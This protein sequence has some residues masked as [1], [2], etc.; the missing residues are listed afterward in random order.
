MA[1]IPVWRDTIVTASIRGTSLPYSVWLD[2]EQIFA[3]Q[4]YALP[5]QSVV[6]I[7][8]NR[9]AADYLSGRI[10][11]D[12]TQAVQEVSTWRGTFSVR[13]DNTLDVLG[14][15]TL[16]T[17]W[18]YREPD[19]SGVVSLSRKL[20]DVVDPRQLL[21][22]SV[23]N[24]STQSSAPV[25]ISTRISDNM[26]V[27][28]LWSGEVEAQITTAIRLSPSDVGKEVRVVADGN[29]IETYRVEQSC[30]RYCLYY[31]NACGGYDSYLVG[32]NTL[33]RDA[34][35]RTTIERRVNNTTLEHGREVIR[36][37]I[38][39][40]WEL[41]TGYLTD[42]EYQLLH[43]LLGSTSVYL[44]DLEE[45]VIHPVIITNNATEY[46][47]YTNQGRKLSRVRID[48][49]AAQEQIRQ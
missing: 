40:K 34:Y 44:H 8:I 37:T 24:L 47:T 12:R 23:G 2:G 5:G 14:E 10:V 17:D 49:E 11:L 35:E 15:Y 46:R 48:V 43:H 33:R 18:T 26:P 3:G 25:N 36:D 1:N 31:L 16:Y 19:M 41:Y 27:T 21:M 13:N 6:E 9:I 28:L 29:L 32:G 30:A 39:P 20:S 4:A 42:A 7:P 22:T 45:D 38:T